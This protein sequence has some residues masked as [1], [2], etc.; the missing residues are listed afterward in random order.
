MAK[1]DKQ[2]GWAIFE[3]KGIM[4][5]GHISHS[6]KDCIKDWLGNKYNDPRWIEYKKYGWTC[7]KVIIKE[8]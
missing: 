8:L 7:R 2:F 1:K 4:R 3:P 5:I 6:R